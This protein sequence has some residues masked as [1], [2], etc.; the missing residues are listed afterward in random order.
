M[1]SRNVGG[2]ILQAQQCLQQGDCVGAIQHCRAGERID[3][4][5][6]DL[7]QIWGLALHKLGRNSEAARQLERAVRL[8]PDFAPYHNSL[9][10]VLRGLGRNEAAADHY[11]RALKLAPEYVEAHINLGNVSADQGKWHEAEQ[12]YRQVL[13]LQPDSAKA[14]N[15]LGLSLSKQGLFTA[16]EVSLRQALVVRPDYPLALK[17]LGRVAAKLCDKPTL[18]ELDRRQL[19][20]DP[21]DLYSYGDLLMLSNYD[22]CLA[23]DE[24]YTRH[25]AFGKQ[26]AA[27]YQPS[28]E[29]GEARKKSDKKLRVGYVSP[30][31]HS[32]H[33]VMTFFKSVLE[34]HASGPYEVYC[35]STTSA[36][37]V[38]TKKLKRSATRWLDAARLD[39]E[40]LA[41][42]IARDRIDI[43]VDLAGHTFGNRLPVFMLKPAP[44]QVTW[45]GYPN[46]TG[47]AAIDYRLTDAIADPPGVSDGLHT[48]QLW[49][50]PNGFLCY[51]PSEHSPEISSPP[52]ERTG[53]ITFGCL[54]NPAKLSSA[55]IA[56]WSKI[57]QQLPSARLL[58]KSNLFEYTET[59]QKFLR[60]FREAGASH[61]Q[62]ELR[63]YRATL[64]EHLE[65]YR[66]IDIALDPFPYNGTTTTCEALWMGVPVVTLAGDRHAARVGASI[67]QGIGRPELV[68]HS[69]QEYL[70]KVVELSADLPR[71]AALRECLRNELEGS[72]ICDA[73]GFTRGLEEAYGQ[74]WQ[75]FCTGEGRAAAGPD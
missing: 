66:E 18:Q 7:Y 4:S 72:R 48:E 63:T 20:L 59:R 16:A 9:G 31:W 12:C 55:T 75:T 62:V 54:N 32:H 11:R 53:A 43:L 25:A 39:Q 10:V 38:E 61:D 41:A 46:T 49:R 2:H 52:V 26:F 34:Q 60:L 1:G 6:S 24:L 8:A 17:N 50:L 64:M 73:E 22:D 68:A 23:A 58:L 33:P 15:G 36:P 56:L 45:L 37:D 44:V 19:E 29:H 74:M 67:L 28:Y 40:Q 35:Y 42:A 65:T 3:R 27:R 47:V 71:L 57:L 51:T 13:S 21:F 30:D 5:N 69:P 70:R 14:L